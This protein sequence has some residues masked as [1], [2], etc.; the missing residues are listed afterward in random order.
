MNLKVI[1]A[2][3][4]FGSVLTGCSAPRSG[5][6][7]VIETKPLTSSS[8]ATATLGTTEQPVIPI[9]TQSVTQPMTQ[10]GTQA[11]TQTVTQ[12]ATQTV[13]QSN[14]QP[15]ISQ[16]EDD[17]IL[18]P[19]LK[20]L[21]GLK[22]YLAGDWVFDGRSMY[23]SDVVCNLLIDDSLNFQLSFYDA[24]EKKSKGDYSGQIKLERLYANP[25]DVPDLLTIELKDTNDL[26]GEFFYLH[27]TNY[28]GKFVMAWFTTGRESSIFDKLGSEEFAEIPREIIFEKKTETKSRLLPRKNAE[29]YAV[30]WG[31]GSKGKALWLD[32][33]RWIPKEEHDF[34]PVYPLEMIEYEN[35]VYE[36]VLYSISPDQIKDITG[37][38]L[39]PG[40][41]YFVATDKA[42]RIKE[43]VQAERK[44]FL[45]DSNAEYNSEIKEMIWAI[46]TND[47]VEVREYLDA[48]MSILI[49]AETVTLDG[50]ECYQVSLGTGDDERFTR[51]IYY[52]V[53]LN[54]EQVYR[55]DPLTDKWEAVPLG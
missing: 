30:Y 37:D 43:F 16:P 24:Y 18:A 5:A 36:S 22:K 31:K 48:G 40:S 17:L 38:D 13:V 20:S 4:I 2:V 51:E 55:Y 52:A 12:T 44:K 14:T 46:I 29:F 45:E 42:G 21:D 49:E 8:N 47:I 11:A 9:T 41:V 33:V 25:G 26:G 34:A 19:D 3:L 54:T 27:R 28:G 23:L 50:D 10:A 53:N 32:D 7:A 6:G 35:D 15:L 1:T 39:F